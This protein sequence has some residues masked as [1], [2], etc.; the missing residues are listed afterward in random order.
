MNSNDQNPSLHPVGKFGFPL[1]GGTPKGRPEGAVFYRLS[2]VI[3]IHY[4]LLPIVGRH[5]SLPLYRCVGKRTLQIMGRHIGLPLYWCVG[6]RTLRYFFCAAALAGNSPISSA[7]TLKSSSL[8]LMR[9][10]FIIMFSFRP[11]LKSVKSL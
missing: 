3:F 6:K 11:A 4:F 9:R 1:F 7:K 2:V 10:P 5:I 8:N